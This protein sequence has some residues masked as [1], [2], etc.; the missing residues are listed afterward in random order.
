MIRGCITRDFRLTFRQPG[1]KCR[2]GEQAV[3]WNIR[4][5]TGQTGAQG[6]KG[7]RG[8]AGPPGSQGQKGATGP[9]GDQ[10]DDGPTGPTGQTGATGLTGPTG[11]AGPTGATGADGQAGSTGP[12]GPAGDGGPTGPTGQ[13]GVTGPTGATSTSSY[14]YVYNVSPQ[15]VPI[16]GDIT[17][18]QSGPTSPDFSFAPGSPF[19]VVLAGG[20]YEVDFSASVVEPNQLALA[21]NGVALP[22]TLYGS[23][24][25]TD[26]NAGRAIVTLV[27][28][29]LLSLRN[30]SSSSAI[31]LQTLAGGTGANVNASLLLHKLE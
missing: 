22:H 7:D 17:F 18:D 4:G 19:V 11:A 12:T 6:P 20:T 31:S 15:V 28:G 2:R 29:D 24:A 26:Q 1:T 10:G 21:V 3:A 23:G 16:G 13:A 27:G 30:E 14:A 5:L 8:E 9:E 25:G